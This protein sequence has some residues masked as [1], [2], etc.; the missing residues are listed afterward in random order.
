MILF[1]VA[2]ISTLRNLELYK[3]ERDSRSYTP[4]D[5]ALKYCNIRNVYIIKIL[6][7]CT[8][9]HFWYT[10]RMVKNCLHF[11]P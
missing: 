9:V 5:Y 3:P 4:R 6:K 10:L 1:L 11:F 2:E 7:L 8:V